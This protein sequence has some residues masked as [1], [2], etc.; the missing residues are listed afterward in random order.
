MQH[1]DHPLNPLRLA[2]LFRLY[3][4]T[5]AMEPKYGLRNAHARGER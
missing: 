1:S 3:G 4:G 2:P 5:L